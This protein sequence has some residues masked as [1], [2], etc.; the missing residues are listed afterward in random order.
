MANP[1]DQGS[2]DYWITDRIPFTVAPP[3]SDDTGDF[4]KWITD[5]IYWWE[6][7]SQ[8]RIPR[9][10]FILYQTPAIV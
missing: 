7:A 4:E 9:Y 5:R 6:Y 2:F 8:G 10:G 1:Q 3:K